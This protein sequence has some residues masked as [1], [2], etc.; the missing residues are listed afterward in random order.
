V[1]DE[2]Q[3]GE[4]SRGLFVLMESLGKTSEAERYENVLGGFYGGVRKG[5]EE[6]CRAN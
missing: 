6:S 1:Y 3:R 5:L 2:L 4:A